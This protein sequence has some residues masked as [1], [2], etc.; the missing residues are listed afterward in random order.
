MLHGHIPT[1]I[2]VPDIQ[3]IKR[4]DMVDIDGLTAGFP[5]QDI[6]CSGS[7][8]GFR[9]A[10][11]SLF[12]HIIRIAALCPRL[13]FMLL[14]NVANITSLKMM[15]LFLEILKLLFSVGFTQMRWVQVS[16]TAAGK[17]H[18][19]LRWIALVTRP[20]M[21]MDR[22]RSLVH[23][24]STE[25]FKNMAKQPWQQ[26]LPVHRWLL[27]A[28]SDEEKEELMQLGNAVVPA[29]ASMALHWLAHV[30]LTT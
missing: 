9:K 28:Q 23:N 7:Q 17:P 27:I 22:L 6:G 19:R 26:D 10:R 29:C 25:D 15:R 2:I 5:C 21:Q 12:R 18:L 16:A 4:E 8:A 3:D 13:Q 24:L 14:E 20:Q 30:P 1:G 11:S